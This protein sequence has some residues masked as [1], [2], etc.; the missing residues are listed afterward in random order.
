V[1]QV[2][3]WRVLENKIAT[4]VNLAWRGVTTDV[5][6]CC[7]CRL[8]E[9]STSHLLFDCKIAWLVWGQCSA[10]LGVSSTAS[11]DPFAHFLQFCNVIKSFNSVLGSVWIS[12]VREI[13]CHR[14]KVIFKGGV[15]DYSE[16][17]TL[18]QLKAWSWVTSK[19]PSACFSFSDW[20][21]APLSCLKSI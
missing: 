20:C 8:K 6:V 5:L 9:E 18:A 11:I 19:I 10:W 3:A 14:N 1:A 4:K 21:L 16:I 17:F 2:L 13:W 7:F 15:V 12:M